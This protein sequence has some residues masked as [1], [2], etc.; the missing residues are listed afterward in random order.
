V[1]L[2]AVT[3]TGKD[4]LNIHVSRGSCFLDPTDFFG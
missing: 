2:L 1:P 3:D 4:A